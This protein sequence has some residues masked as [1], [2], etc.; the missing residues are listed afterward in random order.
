MKD[1]MAINENKILVIYDSASGNTKKM[2]GLVRDGAASIPETE[3]RLLNVNEASADDLFWCEGIACG[4]PTYVGLVSANM[5]SWWDDVVGQ[6]WGKVDGK[7]GCAFASSGGRGGGAEIVCQSIATIMLNFGM[8]V[9]GVPDYTGQ[10]QTLHYGAIATGAP[11]EG[12]ESD[13]CV[14]LG[15]RLAEWVAFYCH[16]KREYDPL[17]QAYRK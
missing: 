2:A 14:R 11:N 17:K 12:P 1:I 5:K 3:V 6:A 9:F 13:A 4:S 7:I 8:L 15:K 16:G 10:G